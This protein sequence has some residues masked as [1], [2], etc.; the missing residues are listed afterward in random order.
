MVTGL[1]FRTLAEAGGWTTIR[2]E[3]L[4][5]LG[6]LFGQCKCRNVHIAAWEGILRKCRDD[7]L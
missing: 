6:R 7:V 2:N 4:Y 3:N 1:W 5:F